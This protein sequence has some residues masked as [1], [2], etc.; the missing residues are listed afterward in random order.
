MQ[1]NRF[2]SDESHKKNGLKSNATYFKFK[3]KVKKNDK[4]R[5]NRAFSEFNLFTVSSKYTNK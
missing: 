2:S 5:A 3:M 4:F 1:K